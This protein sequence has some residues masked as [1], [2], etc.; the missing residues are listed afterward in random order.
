MGRKLKLESQVQDEIMAFL[1]L[2]EWY[3]VNVHGHAFMSGLPDLFCC[4][5]KYG[6]RWV[7]I[8]CP[9]YHRFTP[10]QLE[11]FQKLCAHASGVWIMTAATEEEYLK[12]FK[13]PNWHH[14]ISL[15]K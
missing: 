15:I 4:H 9:P 2:R 12:L 5:Y 1:R 13:P 7:E 10:A 11:R 14:F 6:H 8:K 3:V